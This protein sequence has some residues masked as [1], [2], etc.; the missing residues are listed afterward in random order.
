MNK[1]LS[2]QSPNAPF[3]SIDNH[4][5]SY[6]IQRGNDELEEIE[7][8]LLL[9]GIFDYYGYDFRDYAQ[10]TLKRRVLMLMQ[11]AG[12]ETI[13]GLL[14]AL[15]HQ[16]ALFQRFIEQ[17]SITVSSLYRDPAMF[18][19][20]RQ[21]IAPILH[22][23]PF[24]RIWHAGCAQGEELY[25]MAILLYETGLYDKCRIYATD[26][27]NDALHKAKQGIYPAKKV[28]QYA[29]NYLQAGGIS[30]LSDYYTECYEHIRFQPWLRQNMVFSYHNLAADQSFNEFNV[31]LCRNVMVYFNQKL[32][33]QVH[34]LLY[35]SLAMFG[36]LILG[37]NE[38]LMLTPAIDYYETM[39]Q[40]ER[41]Y[42]KVQ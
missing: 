21:E 5:P 30:Y 16:P 29:D 17:V 15:L 24:I 6:T 13:S 20:F 36:F 38:S 19:T 26:I 25:A 18:A 33:T 28:A 31:I 35:N 23:Y 10:D 40:Q 41:I 14:S 34:E 22:T 12:I 7:F 37:H 1:Y 11:Q 39:N 9:E 42:R 3:S 4:R 2:L 32:Q 27:N 8:R